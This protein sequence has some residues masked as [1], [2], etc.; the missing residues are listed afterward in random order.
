MQS[1]RTHNWRDVS[2]NLTI[3]TSMADRFLNLSPTDRW[4]MLT[5]TTSD[6][7]QAYSAWQLAEARRQA[8]E[9][10]ELL[11]KAEEAWRQTV[12]S[13]PGPAQGSD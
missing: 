2:R 10:L 5:T 1:P 9:I 6:R 4:A 13:R 12:C 7:L 8:N 3:V 11:D